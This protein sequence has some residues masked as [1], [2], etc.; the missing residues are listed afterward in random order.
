MRLRKRGRLRGKKAGRETGVEKR[1]TAV[2]PSGKSNIFDL[3]ALE[4]SAIVEEVIDGQSNLKS[5]K[6]ME[7]KIVEPSKS[8]LQTLTDEMSPRREPKG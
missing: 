3:T 7:I 1:V 4:I 8:I 6:G 2:I 5:K